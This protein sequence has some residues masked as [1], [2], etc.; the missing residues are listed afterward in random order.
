MILDLFAGPGGWDEGLK[1]RGRTDVIGAE[2]DE[3]ACATATA[4]GHERLFHRKADVY[5]LKPDR[6][7]GVEGLI[8]S[9]PCQ[10]FSPAGLKAGIGDMGIVRDL[11][12]GMAQGID[13]RAEV[14]FD[15][16]DL[17]SI[18]M[19]EPLRFAMELRPRWV[20]CEQVPAV[21]PLWELTAEALRAIGYQTWTGVLSSER[22]GVPQTRRRAFLLAH[23]DRQPAPPVATH[24]AYYPGDP[25][26]LD[27]G[28][29]RWVS[30]SDALGVE[31]DGR[32]YVSSKMDNSARRSMSEPA[33]TI[34]FGNAAMDAG[35]MTPGGGGH[36]SP[37]FTRVSEVE[38][39]VL[40]SF[41]ADYPWRGPT[42]ERFQQI[43]NAVP[44][45]MAAAVV[46]GL[47]G[48]GRVE[49]GIVA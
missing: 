26:R 13:R 46:G 44:P 25:T 18:H 6:F 3:W 9:T 31:D 12:S 4:A 41:R 15:I 20:A 11:I 5:G 43:A 22:Y 1:M 28:V 47:L 33:P 16:A 17:R 14:F 39:A 40:Q 19:V 45:R 23:L 29:E 8:A 34:A 48:V 36:G 38:A 27:A 37:D 35:W 32:L 42:S 7:A 2:I 24:S 21:L 10:G 49:A 30:M